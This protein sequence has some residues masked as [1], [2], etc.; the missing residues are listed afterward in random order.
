LPDAG[1]LATR[2]GQ[3]ME[4]KLRFS[5][6]SAS[7]RVADVQDHSSRFPR[8]SRGTRACEE[9]A[10]GREGT[11]RRKAL[12]TTRAAG[13]GSRDSDK[14][15]ET[16]AQVG[17]RKLSRRRDAS[18]TFRR[19]WDSPRSEYLSSE[20][21]RTADCR[22]RSKDRGDIGMREMRSAYIKYPRYTSTP[23]WA[24]C[25]LAIH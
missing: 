6:I 11:K 12:A 20:R 7:S 8:Q 25:S 3:R 13:R 9:R 1:C 2:S 15:G 10:L 23:Q 18:A 21:R 22:M 14:R 19:G 5:R 17:G 4:Y 16:C 24:G